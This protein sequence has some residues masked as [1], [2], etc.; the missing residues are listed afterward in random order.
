MEVA[1]IDGEEYAYESI[2]DIRKKQIAKYELYL[3]KSNIPEFYWK[4][5][6]EHYK[7]NQESK[8]FKDIFYYAENCH[9]EEFN[10]VHL[11]LYGNHSTQKS[12]LMYNIGKTALKNGLKV[13]S[14]LA[15]T[16]IDK[17]MKLQGFN[18]IEELYKQ[19]MELKE[20]D[21]LLID[22]FG[23]VEKSLMWSSSNKS[24]ILTEW[25]KFLREVLASRTKIVMTSNYD[26]ENIGQVFGKSLCELIDRNFYAIHLTESIKE[27]RQYNVSKVF[28]KN[29][30]RRK[31]KN[32]S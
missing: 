4:I 2:E 19:I 12:A 13:K 18:Y 27:I 16:L 23:D 3:R 7:G 20:V 11:F 25:D 31:T 21:L 6:F 14:I 30:L 26:K 22:D 10:H 1:I 24:I 17:L 8:E 9:T 15:G 5:D 32:E 29:I 28:Q